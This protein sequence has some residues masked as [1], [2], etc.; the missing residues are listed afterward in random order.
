M[1]CQFAKREG[2]DSSRYAPSVQPLAP[3][4]NRK[5]SVRPTPAPFSEVCSFRLTKMS[6]F[7]LPQMGHLPLPLT[8]G[9]VYHLLCASMRPRQSR[10]GISR[11]VRAATL[12]T[13][14]SMRPR[15][16][17]LGIS[18][19]N[20]NDLTLLASFNEAEAITPRNRQILR[21]RV[22]GAVHASMRPRQSRL[23]MPGARVRRDAPRTASMR[24]RQS[25]LGIPEP[26]IRSGIYGMLQ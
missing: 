4:R 7:R 26:S 23:G 19:S 21:Q 3:D 1:S 11:R 20:R 22:K 24:P 5:R 13:G 2:L 18:V 16:S 6:S 8:V 25:R 9:S 15:Q 14:A 12:V 10:L 17:R